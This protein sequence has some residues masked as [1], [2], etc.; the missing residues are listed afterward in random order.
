MEKT[1]KQRIGSMILYLRVRKSMSV[2]SMAEQLKISCKTLHGIEKGDR[3]YSIDTLLKILKYHQVTLK[4][5]F[6]LV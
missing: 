6:D 3:G 2:N 1:M 5:F 4:E